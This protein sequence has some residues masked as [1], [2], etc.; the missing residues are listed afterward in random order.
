MKMRLGWR[1]VGNG[2]AEKEWEAAEW[3]MGDHRKEWEGV[4]RVGLE[5]EE[6]RVTSV[7]Q[8]RQCSRYKLT[9]HESP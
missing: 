3:G 2:R 8:E 9:P 5:G 4:G 6:W 7:S 1:K